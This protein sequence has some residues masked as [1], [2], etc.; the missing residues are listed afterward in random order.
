[1]TLEVRATPIGGDP[2][3]FLDVVDDIYRGDP[4]WVRPLDMEVRDRLG[5]DN[6]FF[7]H[8]EAT[9]LTA[10]RGGRCL[11]RA[12][13]QVDREHLARHGDDTGF[14]GYLDTVD[15]AEVARALL[16]QAAAWLRSRGMKA[17]RGPFSLCINDEIGCL[18]EGFDSPPTIMM[19]HHRPYQGGLIEAAGLRKNKDVLAWHYEVGDIPDRARKA[20]AAVAGMPEV[21][22]RRVDM[23]NLQRDVRVIMDVFNDAWSD[24]WGF[25]PLTEAEIRKLAS[26]LRLLVVPDLTRLVEIGGEPV[27]VAV[28]LPNLNE[29]IGDLHG[30][31]FPFGIVKLLWRLKVRGVRSG[32][33]LILGIKKKLRQQRRYGGLSTFLYVET[34]LAAARLGLRTGELSWTLE[35][36]TP[37]N[38][39]IKFMGGRVYK[40]YRIYEREL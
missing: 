4:C 17:M 6:P 23:A 13:A 24:N 3:A 30:K 16:E 22:A 40:R 7:Q 1:M 19:P 31:L 10:H 8:A 37:V 9:V 12:T 38:L 35:D 2:R 21:T 14:F 39:G 25:V 32:R 11:G 29:A 20:H 28:T 33:V 34:H 36:N 27:A 26:D 5:P 18:V 15:E